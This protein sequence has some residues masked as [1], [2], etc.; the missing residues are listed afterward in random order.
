VA[1]L[2]ELLKQQAPEKYGAVDTQVLNAEISRRVADPNQRAAA[3][4]HLRQIFPAVAGDD[5]DTLSAKVIRGAGQVSQEA[6]AEAARQRQVRSQD[7]R[8]RQ[9]YQRLRTEARQNERAIAAGTQPPSEVVEGALQ[10]YRREVPTPRSARMEQD[11][12]DQQGP[13]GTS[14]RFP[15]GEDFRELQALAKK[16][17]LRLIL[18]GHGFGLQVTAVDAGNN[19]RY[20]LSPQASYDPK[21]IEGASVAGYF[22]GTSDPLQGGIASGIAQATGLDKTSTLGQRAGSGTRSG[23]GFREL[24]G[25]IG[26]RVAPLIPGNL[27]AKATAAP[28]EAGARAL[29]AIDRGEAALQEGAAGA[30]QGLG[31][32][33]GSEWLQNTPV[34]NRM[35][36]ENRAEAA[37]ETGTA[38]DLANFRRTVD[39]LPQEEVAQL[40]G[41]AFG[42]TVG[43]VAQIAAPTAAG[44]VGGPLASK[45]LAKAAPYAGKAGRAALAVAERTPVARTV[46]AGARGA[47][48]L[49]KKILTTE[50]GRATV[51][52]VAARHGVRD[53]LA[54]EVLEGAATAARTAPG[55]YEAG[56][57]D[58]IMEQLEPVWAKHGIT[59]PAAR[60]AA[61]R[62][63]LQRWSR[64]EDRVAAPTL[65]QDIIDVAQP[66]HRQLWEQ[67]GLK[68]M[69]Q[70]Y[71]PL[72]P[73]WGQDPTKAARMT[74]T[75]AA[76][77]SEAVGENA[78][79]AAEV[80][81]TDEL[82]SVP[83]LRK[84]LG[85]DYEKVG[86][87]PHA[88]T[89]ADD[90][91]VASM[92][93]MSDIAG[94]VV[95]RL[96]QSRGGINAFTGAELDDVARQFKE[97]SLPEAFARSARHVA[98]DQN[99]AWKAAAD[100]L[101]AALPDLQKV[102]PQ[103]YEKLETMLQRVDPQ[104]MPHVGRDAY[105]NLRGKDRVMS[106]T[107][108]AYLRDNDLV[109]IRVEGG[110][111]DTPRTT[112]GTHD[113][114]LPEAFADHQ[115]MVVDR[116][117]GEA[118]RQMANPSQSKT[119][120]KRW[121]H[122]IDH[123]LGLTQSK[124][125]ITGGNPGFTWRVNTGDLMRHTISEGR[126]G[127]RPELRQLV[128]DL[129]HV[130]PGSAAAARTTN[131]VPKPGGG[132]WTLGELREALEKYGDISHTFATEVGREQARGPGAGRL[133]ET[134]IGERGSRIYNRTQELMNA[135]GRASSA[136]AD[137]AFRDMFRVGGTRLAPTFSAG[138]GIRML[139]MLAMMRR[140]V[141]PRVAGNRMRTLMVDFGNTTAL[142]EG[143]RP[144]V[145][146]IKFWSQGMAGALEMARRN[147]RGFFRLADVAR[148]MEG[149]DQATQ[150]GAMD[151]RTKDP[152]D[153]ISM[154]PR[155]ETSG[156][157][158]ATLRF[159]NPYQ[160]VAD[161]VD[162]V[163]ATGDPTERRGVGQFLGP[164]IAKAGAFLTGKDIATGRSVLGVDKDQASRLSGLLPQQLM[165]AVR[166]GMLTE[167]QAAYLMAK[168]TPG[169]PGLTSPVDLGLRVGAHLGGSTAQPVAEDD[170]GAIERALPNWSVGV[171][172][173]RTDPQRAALDTVSRAGKNM[174]TPLRQANLKRR[175]A[176]KK[177]ARP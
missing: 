72:H 129:S 86:V 157:R 107:Q 3:L 37:R 123:A 130:R 89:G 52:E 1:T 128:A 35:A 109:V 135:A 132:V 11:P 38:E 174:P 121:A 136:A 7:A 144:A 146:F 124:M 14:T 65:V 51:D 13:A 49:G 80:P 111:A 155:F 149:W 82:A 56:V 45:A 31:R 175:L 48:D 108:E 160:D 163:A 172:L 141:N 25:D 64:V 8:L 113:V 23:Y 29:S 88:L 147:P 156:G 69:G 75:S 165:Q 162:A 177:E 53:P 91:G 39:E 9:N 50:L 43:E 18:P 21:D 145:P 42:R 71:N 150:G 134:V 73:L 139:N 94:N 104:A 44:M 93:P 17:G 60:G 62:E 176:G 103:R 140:G 34:L 116:W 159:E 22:T 151:P 24:G 54:G 5:D 171:R 81:L 158:A 95:E 161:I 117:Y 61:L 102:A 125:A 96:R 166:D 92:R 127:L 36:A 20:M 168:W 10:D 85:V 28:L 142:Q 84:L 97:M 138:E 15:V 26:E 126:E 137:A 46:V 152:M 106:E 143:L 59:D 76:R 122:D 79:K 153:Q 101:A 78:W 40:G 100:D 120:V 77:A 68:E 19:P 47:R 83:G 63:A 154:R 98:G 12:V 105:G 173:R 118:M 4:Q 99:L 90:W 16:E 70:T 110:K 115:N 119:L 87:G 2:G 169:T 148:Y 30:L 41:Q 66:Y 6:A 27:G 67:G 58:T 74:E 57:R 133:I 170:V 112:W 131:L 114:S 167:G 33:V 164:S 55:R 32:A